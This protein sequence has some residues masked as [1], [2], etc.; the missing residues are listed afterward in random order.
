MGIE[1]F[2][3]EEMANATVGRAG[4]SEYPGDDAA[5]WDRGVLAASCCCFLPGAMPGFFHSVFLLHL[6]S[7]LLPA[8]PL[9][10]NGCLMMPL[11]HFTSFLTQI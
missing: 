11:L 8:L 9:G 7:N 2:L 3:L 1:E 5:G 4:Y 6:K 10:L